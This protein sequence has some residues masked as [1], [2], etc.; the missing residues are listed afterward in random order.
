MEIRPV[1][2]AS[3]ADL[4]GL[5]GT[6]RSAAGC[7]CMWFI[8]PVRDFHAAGPEGNRAR[9]AALAAQGGPPAG[10]IGY[11][12]GEAVGWCAVGPRARYARAIRTPT[13]AGRDPTEDASVW[14][15]P[16]LFLRRDARGAGR[17]EALVAAGVGLARDHGASAIEAF[18][19][20]AGRRRS[21]D[22]QVGFERI[23][24]RCG[25]APVRRPSENRVIVRRALGAYLQKP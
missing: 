3:L 23:F 24:A 6:E 12:D 9:F 21:A 7:W 8:V 10:L 1:D 14:L 5:L 25:F 13:F 20:V 4:G 18:P 2:A 15:I 16:C 17:G 11:R 22:T 19:F